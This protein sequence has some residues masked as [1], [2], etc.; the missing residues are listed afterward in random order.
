MF[1][2]I[3]GAAGKGED[4]PFYERPGPFLDTGQATSFSMLNLDR[5]EAFVALLAALGL[6][7]DEPRRNALTQW[8]QPIRQI[9]AGQVFHQQE[10]TQFLTLFLNHQR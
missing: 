5:P 3:C 8:I 4:K 9:Q 1:S 7:L 10:Q 2:A 6:P